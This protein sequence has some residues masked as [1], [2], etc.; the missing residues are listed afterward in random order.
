[1]ATSTKS[2]KKKDLA[3]RKEEHKVHTRKGHGRKERDER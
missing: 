2:K 1:M 3:K